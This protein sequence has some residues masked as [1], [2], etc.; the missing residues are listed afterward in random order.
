L[1]ALQP[2]GPYHLLA[3]SYGTIPLM[4]MVLKLQ[5]HGEQVEIVLIDGSLTSLQTVARTGVSGA[6]PAE[7]EANFL[8]KLMVIVGVPD[9]QKV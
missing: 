8:E 5:D 2:K 7:W 1:R 9:A 3:Y 4:E 6:S